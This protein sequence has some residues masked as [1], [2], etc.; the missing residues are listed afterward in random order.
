MKKV[1]GV[2]IFR[3]DIGTVINYVYTEFDK[4]GVI[5]KPQEQRSKIVTTEDETAIAKAL[6]NYCQQ[7]ADSEG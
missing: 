1:T 3:R 4:N 6:F 7:L 5:T 2:A